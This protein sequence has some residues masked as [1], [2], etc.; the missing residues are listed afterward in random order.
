MP[1]SVARSHHSQACLFESPMFRSE[2][3]GAVTQYTAVAGPACEDQSALDLIAL[4]NALSGT[5]AVAFRVD[6]LYD[7]CPT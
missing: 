1:S 2:L 3:E 7:S 6:P 5:G 4:A